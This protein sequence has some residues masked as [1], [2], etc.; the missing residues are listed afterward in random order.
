MWQVGFGLA[1]LDQSLFGRSTLN[2]GNEKSNILS[3]Y[4]FNGN[5]FSNIYMGLMSFYSMFSGSNHQF[6]SLELGLSSR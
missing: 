4:G 1:E 6:P 2:F 3:N 5:K